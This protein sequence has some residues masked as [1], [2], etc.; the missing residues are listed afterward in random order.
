MCAGA[1]VA[2]AKVNYGWVWQVCRLL[3]A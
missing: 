2:Q 1:P 3:P